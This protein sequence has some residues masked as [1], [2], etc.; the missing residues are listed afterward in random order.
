M[1]DYDALNQEYLSLQAKFSSLASEFHNNKSGL[2]SHQEH[3]TN[4][5]YFMKK[6]HDENEAVKNN[7]EQQQSAFNVD[8]VGVKKSGDAKMRAL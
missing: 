6:S 4:V 5:A 7:L 2:A 3:Q 1:R 8:A